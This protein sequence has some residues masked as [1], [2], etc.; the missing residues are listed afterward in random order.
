[1]SS[2][3]PPYTLLLV[4]DN[5]DLLVSIRFALEKL[6]GFRVETAADGVE[7][8]QRTIDLH[9]ACI[10]IDV[11]MPGLDG[12]QLVRALRGD[13]ETMDI[14][15]VMLTAMAQDRDRY[16]GLASGAD[17]YITKPIDPVALVATIRRALELTE[18]ERVRQMKKLSDD[19]N[20]PE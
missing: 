16:Q 15:L 20:I 10:I 3:Q 17:Q 2:P 8:L 9:P 6:G 12:Y 7:G 1:M 5:L 4:D 11:K 19:P 14:P 18:A 13:P